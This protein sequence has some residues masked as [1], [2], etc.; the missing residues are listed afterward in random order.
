MARNKD[1]GAWLLQQRQKPWLHRIRGFRPSF[2][3]VLA[4]QCADHLREHA[5]PDLLWWHTANE[6]QRSMATWSMQAAMGYLVGVPDLI[7]IKRAT[8]GLVRIVFIE[9]K[10]PGGK[11]SKPQ[12]YFASVAARLNIPFYTVDT[13]D[14]FGV[15]IDRHG[16]FE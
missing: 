6:S 15:V 13:F 1:R 7:L 5:P 16:L 4:V 11:L 14:H 12:R 2:E 10:K 9:L 3:E 8:D